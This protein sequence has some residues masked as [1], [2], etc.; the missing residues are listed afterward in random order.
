M[1]PTDSKYSSTIDFTTG[2]HE[3]Q[4]DPAR[5]HAVTQEAL[6]QLPPSATASLICCLVTSLHEQTWASS[7]SPISSPPRPSGRISSSGLAG[8]GIPGLV[9]VDTI[10]RS[11]PYADASPTRTP[12]SSRVP[13]SETTSFL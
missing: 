13:S 1:R 4:V 9:E 12:P 5:V 10:G 3:P 11:T 7:G 8:S 6:S 2:L